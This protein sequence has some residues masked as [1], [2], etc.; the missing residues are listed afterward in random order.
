MDIQ[1]QLCIIVEN[2]DK[3]VICIIIKHRRHE[4]Q[5]L[6]FDH[7]EDIVVMFY[8]EKLYRGK[9]NLHFLQLSPLQPLSH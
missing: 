2:K 9:Q 5:Y 3:R 7:L 4:I 1:F 8:K 6:N